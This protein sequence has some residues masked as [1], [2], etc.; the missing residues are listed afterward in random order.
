MRL[1]E[2]VSSNKTEVEVTVRFLCR[3]RPE[4]LSAVHNLVNARKFTRE[5]SFTRTYH[6]W[7]PSSYSYFIFLTE[8]LSKKWSSNRN[9]ESKG[10]VKQALKIRSVSYCSF[11][12]KMQANLRRTLRQKLG[13][14]WWARLISSSLAKCLSQAVILIKVPWDKGSKESCEESQ[15][16][17]VAEISEEIEESEVSLALL[18]GLFSP[19]FFS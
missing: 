14:N 1:R 18:T 11:F 13:R 5:L 19:H 2:V 6:L 12:V 3:V 4:P 15:D 10:N 16:F 7:R 9:A 8:L 17:W